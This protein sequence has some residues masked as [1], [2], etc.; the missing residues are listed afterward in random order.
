MIKGKR[1]YYPYSEEMIILPE[2]P[3]LPFKDKT[4]LREM[5]VQKMKEKMINENWRFLERSEYY[6]EAIFESKVP[7]EIEKIENEKVFKKL[8]IA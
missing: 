7:Q 1:G 4:E 6:F 3:E 5:Y 8:K 2:Y